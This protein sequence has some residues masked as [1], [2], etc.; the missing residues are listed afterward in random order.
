MKNI[1]LLFNLNKI[2]GYRGV[3]NFKCRQGSCTLTKF[4][5][6]LTLS[7]PEGADYTHGFASPKRDYTPE[8]IF[9]TKW[10]STKNL[11]FETD[12]S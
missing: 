10:A 4:S 5:D 2:S 6:A 1:Q 12:F 3:V 8:D 7:Q 11:L 9:R